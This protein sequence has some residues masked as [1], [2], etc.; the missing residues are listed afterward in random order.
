MLRRSS[1]REVDAFLRSRALDRQSNRMK[2]YL[3]S[4][5]TVF[6]FATHS[7]HAGSPRVGVGDAGITG[8]QLRPY[9]NLWKFTQQK[10]GGVAEQGG[11]L[12]RFAGEHCLQWPACNEEDADRELREKGNQV[13]LCQCFRS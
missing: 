3:V 13:D 11:H 1:R 2:T 9:T 7:L 6:W 8:S 12:E 4:L 5:S 10:P